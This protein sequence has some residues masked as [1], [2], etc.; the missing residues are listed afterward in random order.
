MSK[1]IN[2]FSYLLVI[3]A[4]LFGSG[5]VRVHHVHLTSIDA[6]A[7]GEAI[8]VLIDNVGVDAA[9]VAKNIEALA[10]V[11]RGKKKSNNTASDMIGTFQ[12]GPKTG[13]PVY[14]KN[15]GE[16]LLSKLLKKCPSAQLSNVYSQ[17]LTTDYGGSGV[18]RETVIVKATCIKN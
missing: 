6:N 1:K 15:W 12:S 3:I 4:I 9:K 18:T 17:R 10:S 7:K 14:Q 13:A 11:F 5:C 8:E 16:D 2:P